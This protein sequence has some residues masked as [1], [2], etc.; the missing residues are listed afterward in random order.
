MGQA[1]HWRLPSSCADNPWIGD[2]ARNVDT[3]SAMPILPHI[4]D[5]ADAAAAADLVRRL[6]AAAADEAA[7]R[8]D[9]SRTVG[10]VRRFCRWRQVGRLAALLA[11]ERAVGTLH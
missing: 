9:A 1:G 4:H 2:P 3:F 5:A 7:A 10:N 11:T 8:A 6:G